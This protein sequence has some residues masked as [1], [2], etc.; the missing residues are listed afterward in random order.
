MS[1]TTTTHDKMDETGDFRIRRVV[2][3]NFVPKGVCVA[4]NPYIPSL[5][6]EL[7][8][9]IFLYHFQNISL[10]AKIASD[11]VLLVIRVAQVPNVK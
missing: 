10:T 4:Y 7:I 3:V 11:I 9:N 2:F 8:T 6:L 5:D 1:H